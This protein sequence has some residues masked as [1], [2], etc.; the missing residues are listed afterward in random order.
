MRIPDYQVTGEGKV[1]IYLLHGIYGAKDYW[2]YQTARLV[3]KGYRVVAWDAPGY[4][5]TKSLPAI[6]LAHFAIDFI[7]FAGVIPK[8][9]FKFV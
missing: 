3:G 9:I 2:R 7:D 5:K 8:S 1:T 6:M 4:L